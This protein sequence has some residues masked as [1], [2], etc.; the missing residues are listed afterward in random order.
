MNKIDFLTKYGKN[1]KRLFLTGLDNWRAF[2]FRKNPRKGPLGLVWDINT[3][4]NGRCIYCDYWR[5]G[6]D[7]PSRPVELSTKD[8]LAII[9]KIGDAGIW[10][11]SFCKGEPLISEDLY[12][13][14]R[15]AKGRGMLVNISTNGFLL[16]KHARMLI[17]SGV[18]YLTVSVHS[19][20]PEIHDAMTG[21]AGS[22]NEIEKGIAAIKSLRLKSRP[23]ITARCL[24]SRR[25]GLALEEFIDYWDG[26]ADDILFKLISENEDP[27]YSIP[28]DL[29]FRPEDIPLF[30]DYFLRVL[31]QNKKLDTPYHRELPNRLLPDHESTAGFMCF[32]GT[33]FANMD[34]WGNIFHCLDP[35]QPVGNILDAGFMDIWNSKK[36][37]DLRSAL[38]KDGKCLGCWSDRFHSNTCIQALMFP[39][40][41]LKRNNAS[42][43]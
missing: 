6:Q 24:I 25:N 22:F 40:G 31:S 32:A 34:P 7:S 11:L 18:D 19:H 29:S 37:M 20:R 35:D 17:D 43:Q 5:T 13:L 1:T 38:R 23:H 10:L 16:E 33:F 9:R 27:C 2:L 3:A 30:T 12:Q 14:V 8:R 42:V 41:R 28:D 4:C 36:M 15:E 39:F 26:K 21:V